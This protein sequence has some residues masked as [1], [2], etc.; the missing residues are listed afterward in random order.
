MPISG[1]QYVEPISG[2]MNR[3]LKVKDIVLEKHSPYQLIEVVETEDYGRVLFLDSRFQTSEKDEF[4]YHE[5]L[6]HPAMMTHPDPRNVL[7]IGGGDGGALEELL[8]Y[9]S[10]ERVTMVELEPDVVETCKE[11]MRAVC[12]DAFSDP[13]LNLVI[14]DGRKVLEE[15]GGSYDV[16]LLDLTD[17]LGPSKYLYTQE[18]YRLCAAR[19]NPGGLLGL[20]NDSPFFYPKAFNVIS[21]TLDSVF[22]GKIQYVT[23]VVG[24]MLDFAFSVCSP[25]PLEIPSLDELTARFRQRGLG[26][27]MWYSPA[28]HSA[29]GEIPGY[30]RRILNAPC[31]VSTDANPY[32]IDEI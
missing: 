32:E 8:K 21:K 31:R 15:A 5:A 19:L 22:P 10:V 11:Y 23:Y 6:V 14:A 3:T 9:P 28:L 30:L 26:G 17:P 18:F 16:I 27:L 1:N 20:H 12:G 29:L 2:S 25:A 4:F 7:I 13:R 24:Y